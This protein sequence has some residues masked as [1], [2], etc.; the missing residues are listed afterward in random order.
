MKASLNRQLHGLA[1]EIAG[2]GRAH[3]YLRE[4]AWTGYKREHLNELSDL[5]AKFLIASLQTERA[6]VRKMVAQA[7]ATT[8]TGGL[9]DMGTGRLEREAAEFAFN[10]LN[11]AGFK[12]AGPSGMITKSQIDYIKELQGLLGW[13]DRYMDKLIAVRY[14]ENYLDTMPN[15][16]ANRLIKL[17]Q[18]RWYSK[19]RKRE[20]GERRK[21]G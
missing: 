6:K 15:W 18:S 19:K 4:L 21:E 17:M 12:D 11:E 5:E 8:E 10:Q 9:G 16:K 14:D 13:H 1:G 2:P 7:V 3:E 20:Q